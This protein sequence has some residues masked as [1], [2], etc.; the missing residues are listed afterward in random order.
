VAKVKKAG[1][2]RK[3]A[4]KPGAK[5]KRAPSGARKSIARGTKGAKPRPKAKGRKV[6]AKKPVVPPPP[7]FHVQELDPQRMCGSGT[8]VQLLYKLREQWANGAVQSHLV[9]FDRHGWY[10]EHGRNCPAV[11]HAQ[12]IGD[13]ARQRG[14]TNNGRMRA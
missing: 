7:V 10:C 9:F 1:A 14:P 12:K 8:S 4:G 2:V 3:V 5:A 6:I 11:P 13:R